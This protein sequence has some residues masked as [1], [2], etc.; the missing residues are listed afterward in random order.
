MWKKGFVLFLAIPALF[1]ENGPTGPSGNSLFGTWQ[2]PQPVLSSDYHEQITAVFNA[3]G[4]MSWATKDYDWDS[5]SNVWEWNSAAS[6]ADFGTYWTDGEFLKL[7][8]DTTINGSRSIQENYLRYEIKGNTMGLHAAEIYDGTSSALLGTWV[9]ADSAY[10][11]GGI[12]FDSIIITFATNGK[13]TVRDH[14]AEGYSSLDSAT[15]FDGQTYY[16]ISHFGHSHRYNYRIRNGKLYS[17]YPD[18]G[19]VF[20]RQ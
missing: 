5:V 3:N 8:F 6:R 15:Y 7:H 20:Y 2:S 13:Y 16:E 11:N 19:L 17:Y 14:F 18:P 10:A 4:A 1:C 9:R 12:A